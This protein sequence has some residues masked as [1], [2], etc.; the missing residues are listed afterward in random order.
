VR[1]YRGVYAAPF[2][3][4]E[5]QAD[6]VHLEAFRVLHEQGALAAGDLVLFTTGDMRGVEGRTNTLQIIEVPG[7]LA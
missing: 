5:M 3:V 6:T 1:L 2:N 7:D 4:V